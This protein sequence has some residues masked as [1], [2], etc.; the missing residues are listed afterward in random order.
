MN[1][2]MSCSHGLTDECTFFCA[3]SEDIGSLVEKQYH[4]LSPLFSGIAYP[5]SGST[6]PPFIRSILNL[7]RNVEDGKEDGGSESQQVGAVTTNDSWL[8][9]ALVWPH[10]FSDAFLS[11]L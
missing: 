4:P 2:E 5:C 9:Y 11:L 6:L 3:N 7:D 10:P 8:A 1:V